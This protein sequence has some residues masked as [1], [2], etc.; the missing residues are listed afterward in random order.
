MNVGFGR[1]GA[2]TFHHSNHHHYCRHYL[3]YYD[4]GAESEK[5]PNQ[6]TTVIR[7][8]WGCECRGCGYHC[9]DCCGSYCSQGCSHD[10]LL[11]CFCFRSC[12]SYS[13]DRAR[14]KGGLKIH[15]TTQI[16]LFL[17]AYYFEDSGQE[18]CSVSNAYTVL[19]RAGPSFSC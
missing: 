17:S 7:I 9:C 3:C 11:V 4:H 8:R 13:L 5:R 12:F 1:F 18:D 6:K 16:V 2:Q 15:I 14:N 10:I 19:L